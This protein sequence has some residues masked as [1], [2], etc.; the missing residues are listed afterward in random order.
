MTS[1]LNNSVLFS[2]LISVAVPVPI[3]V[4]TPKS[5]NKKNKNFLVKVKNKMHVNIFKINVLQ[6]LLDCSVSVKTQEI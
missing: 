3:S 5:L 2:S 4:R 6:E 1:V